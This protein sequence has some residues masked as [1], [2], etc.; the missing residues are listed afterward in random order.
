MEFRGSIVSLRVHV[1]RAHARAQAWY[2]FGEKINCFHQIFKGVCNSRKG[3]DHCCRLLRVFK[4][5]SETLW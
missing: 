3:K 4:Q 1:Y 5:R 2:F